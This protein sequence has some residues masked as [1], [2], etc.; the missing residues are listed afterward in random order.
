MLPPP[1]PPLP[2]AR[3]RFSTG[4]VVSEEVPTRSCLLTRTCTR[5]H[6]GTNARAH[7]PAQ[8]RHAQT[9]TQ[10]HVDR[11]PAAGQRLTACRN[12]TDNRSSA[13][14]P[15][16]TAARHS[17]AGPKPCAGAAAAVHGGEPHGVPERRGARGAADRRPTHRA[18][19]RPIWPSVKPRA[20]P[21]RARGPLPFRPH[22]QAVACAPAAA[23]RKRASAGLTEDG[24]RRTPSM[25][26]AQL[27]PR[28]GWP[29]ACRPAPACGR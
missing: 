24:P 12:P 21:P 23:V 14:R 8:A 17:S 27:R 10:P 2:R 22:T 9:S 19:S 7:S 15:V 28:P 25:T 13:A 20:G 3:Y 5:T 6:K 29:L 16:P 18:G 11:E 26:G 4:I 1:Q